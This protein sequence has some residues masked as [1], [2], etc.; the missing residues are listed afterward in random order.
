MYEDETGIYFLL[1]AIC[2]KQTVHRL[3][4]LCFH[5]EMVSGFCVSMLLLSLI[6]FGLLA[7]GNAYRDGSKNLES[8]SAR[9]ETIPRSYRPGS[10]SYDASLQPRT[11]VAGSKFPG[12][13]SAEM[14]KPII[15]QGQSSYSRQVNG[16]SQPG[17][18]SSYRSASA[19][20]S[21]Q[22][23]QASL[24]QWK[25]SMREPS[26]YQG[27]KRYGSSVVSS[28]AI[29]MRAPENPPQLQSSSPGTGGLETKPGM[30][31]NVPAFQIP[32]Q[33][34]A[35][36][37]LQV[38][39]TNAGMW[40]SVNAKIAK[41]P[42]PVAHR[43]RWNLAFSAPFMQPAKADGWWNVFSKNV[44]APDSTARH[45]HPLAAPGVLKT[46]PGHLY[47][48][49][50]PSALSPVFTA[51]RHK[52]PS[53]FSAPA[54]LQTNHGMWDGMFS[55]ESSKQLPANRRGSRPLALG[56][57]SSRLPSGLAAIQQQ[58]KLL[59]HQLRELGSPASSVL[60]N[61]AVLKDVHSKP[62]TKH[63]PRSFRPVNVE[64]H[65]QHG[66]WQPQLSYNRN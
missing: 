14:S 21:Q 47:N 26:S 59:T 35:F 39:Q 55:L 24:N 34:P 66:S 63:D 38:L 27:E 1:L 56:Y 31:D 22:Q 20:N 58:A 28:G 12:S 25:L 18:V 2:E 41:S 29:E 60:K 50:T 51:Q 16:Y 17:S 64:S 53:S 43:P 8:Y 48:S 62:Q 13:P 4:G 54:V 5:K 36:S 11:S 32:H 46:S 23:P 49:Y 30:W 44:K 61:K 10:S 7:P 9:S 19:L 42:G 33:H 52:K 65:Y 3:F 40:D 57:Y 15:S 45:E 37:A 6:T